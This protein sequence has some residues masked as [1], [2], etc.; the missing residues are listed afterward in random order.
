MDMKIV[1]QELYTYAR[2]VDCD[3]RIQEYGNKQG[4]SLMAHAKS[5]KH[6]VVG[7]KEVSFE[8]NG[9]K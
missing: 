3:W 1:T 5:K 9:K 6:K 8:Y 4:V 7:E 2:C